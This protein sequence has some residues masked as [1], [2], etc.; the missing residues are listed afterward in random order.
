MS[1]QPPP[2][3]EKIANDE[4]KTTLP[5]TLFFN[6]VFD[7]DAGT[8]WAPTFQNL[9]SVGTPTFEGRYYTISNYLTY[10]S[11]LITPATSV[12]ATAGTTYIDNFPLNFAGDGVC[13][14]VSGNL[15]ATPGMING[16]TN[17]VYIPGLSAVTV[18]VTIIGIGEAS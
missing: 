15:G 2:I 9:S 3:Y 7:G 11:V 16:T 10:F 18:P 17:R 4:G 12:S 6:Q 13:F 8:V 5:W 1:I 14:A